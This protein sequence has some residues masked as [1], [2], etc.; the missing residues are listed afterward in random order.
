MNSGEKAE[1][2]AQRKN[3]I[4]KKITEERHMGKQSRV[5]GKFKSFKREQFSESLS[6]LRQIIFLCL[7]F[8]NLSQDP[9]LGC[10]CTLQPRL[11]SK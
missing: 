8:I 5:L 10:A 2:K 4:E 7:P 11:I 1:G 3:L 6:S 9:P